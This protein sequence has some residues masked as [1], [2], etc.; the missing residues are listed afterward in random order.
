MT[1]ELFQ[2]YLTDHS[3]E[4]TPVMYFY[5]T[6]KGGHLSE[7]D[8]NLAFQRWAAYLGSLVA[9]VHYHVFKELTK[10]FEL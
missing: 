2:E 1:K 9:K 6:L 5:Y 3:K 4:V 10:H 7:Y 8:F